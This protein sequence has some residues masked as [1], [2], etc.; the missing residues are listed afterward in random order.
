MSDAQ[1]N[2]FDIVIAGAGMVG[3]SLA[4]LLAESSLRIALIDRNPL[5]QSKGNDSPE[6]PSDKFDPRVSAI[7]RASRHGICPRL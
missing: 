2:E 5:V 6:L 7:S 4:C 3:A 1:I